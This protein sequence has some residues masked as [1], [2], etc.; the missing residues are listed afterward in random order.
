MIALY[1]RLSVAD[2][3]GG[4]SESIANQ[5]LILADFVASRDDL[6][7][8]EHRFFVDDGISGT[9]AENR[10]ALQE[11]LRCCREGRV[12]TVVVKDLSRLSR[13]NLYCV[14]LVEDELPSLGV[15]VIAV[16][17]NYDS[18]R[19]GK[20]TSAGMQLGFKAIMNS[21]Y[22]KDL[23]RKVTQG[24]RSEHA[25]GMNLRTVP[26]AYRKG[27]GE[28]T[29]TADEK[30]APVVRR[31]FELALDGLNQSEIASKLNEEGAIT[32]HNLKVLRSK[33]NK[34]EAKPNQRWTGT[35]VKKIVRN[36][37]Y[38][39]TLV[40]GKTRR[41][42][43]G[44]CSARKTE[45]EERFVFEN[46]HEAIVDA[47]D[48]ARAQGSMA[49]TNRGGTVEP[50]GHLF[51]GFVFCPHC[52]KAVSFRAGRRRRPACYTAYCGCFQEAPSIALHVLEEAVASVV[53]THVDLLFGLSDA[54]EAAEASPERIAELRL[55]LRRLSVRKMRAYEA[56][57]TGERSPEE[58]A[59]LKAAMDSEEASV[60]RAI[61]R[62]E[63]AAERRAP[64]IIDAERAFELA[65][66]LKGQELSRETL[67]AFVDR[68]ELLGDDEVRI[69]LKYA[70]VFERLG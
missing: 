51:T 33:G 53:R 54:I 42:E 16:V 9:H 64:A 37:H 8:E 49:D 29:C 12:S 69:T 17:D 70:D 26:F 11:M 31:I 36:P 7:D 6:K 14:G 39:G 25:R 41:N 67:E 34:W 63:V 5:R 50:L 32:P 15:R 61:E 3:D 28:Y 13:D 10:P 45:P 2:G 66:R 38:K 62:M 27:E 55:S 44:L 19:D 58:F 21:W 59:A 18:R 24:I 56:Y 46:A 40:L 4:E 20:S 1:C 23:S 48:W 52:G 47:A 35:M 22:S 68:I 60:R 43:I 57:R 30:G 65:R